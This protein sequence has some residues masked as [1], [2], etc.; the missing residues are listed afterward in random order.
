MRAN[1]LSLNVDKTSFLLLKLR[2]VNNRE[3][4]VIDVGGR[5]VLMIREAKFIELTVN[6]RLSY[7]QH[8]NSHGKIMWCVIGIV[9]RMLTNI[10]PLIVGWM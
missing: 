1:I 8:V 4:E 2:S 7:N 10:P 6:D 9:N 3:N 5:I